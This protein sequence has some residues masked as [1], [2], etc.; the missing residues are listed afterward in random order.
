MVC[1]LLMGIWVFPVFGEQDNNNYNNVDSPQDIR[2]GP[3]GNT[4]YVGPGQTY[5]KICWDLFRRCGYK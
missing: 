4:L 5:S 1:V 2:G 3:R